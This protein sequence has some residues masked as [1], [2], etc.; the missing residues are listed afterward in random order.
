ML[1]IHIHIHMYVCRYMHM[2]TDY[3]GNFCNCLFGR[4]R[5]HPREREVIAQAG[6]PLGNLLEEHLVNQLDDAYVLRELV[7]LLEV[8]EHH[9][10]A[11]VC[12][13]QINCGMPSALLEHELLVEEPHGDNECVAGIPAVEALR[14]PLSTLH[15]RQHLYGQVIHSGSTFAQLVKTPILGKVED[16]GNEKYDP[17]RAGCNLQ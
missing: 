3:L 11:R 2:Q 9:L 17:T 4:W 13:G 12:P 1:Y 7:Q 8:I 14:Q 10:A 16:E 15:L 6:D 5:R